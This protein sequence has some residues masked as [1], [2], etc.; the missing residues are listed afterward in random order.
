VRELQAIRQ[1]AEEWVREELQQRHRVQVEE[2]EGV[3]ERRLE[4]KQASLI[5]T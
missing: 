4:R 3:E 5:L 2:G 1:G